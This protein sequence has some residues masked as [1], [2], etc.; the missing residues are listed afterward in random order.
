MFVA[1][2]R[3][4]DGRS[5]N[6]LHPKLLPKLTPEGFGRALTLLN[7]ASGKLPEPAQVGLRE[8]TREKET[9]VVTLDDGRNHQSAHCPTASSAH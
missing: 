4:G 1:V 9:A 8:P 7:R 2:E 6:D 3:K 5:H